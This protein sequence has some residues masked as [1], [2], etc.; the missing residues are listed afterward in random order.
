MELER[1]RQVIADKGFKHKWL[2]GQIGVHPSSLSRFLT[3]KSV[4]SRSAMILLFQ[5][6]NI[7][8]ETLRKKAS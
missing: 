1:I 7:D 8:A 3:G 2:A 6:L 4:I 5:V